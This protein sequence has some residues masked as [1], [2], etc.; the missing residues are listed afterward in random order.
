M[1][2]ASPCIYESGDAL[3]TLINTLYIR[4]M[5]R[6]EARFAEPTSGQR[7]WESMLRLLDRDGI[8]DYRR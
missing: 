5:A 3:Q 1:G 6:A 2:R 7:V 8:D 4:G